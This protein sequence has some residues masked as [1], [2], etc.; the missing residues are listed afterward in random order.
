MIVLVQYL[1]PIWN[2]QQQSEKKQQ[3]QQQHWYMDKYRTEM[4]S[5]DM[6]MQFQI[7]IENDQSIFS[8]YSNKISKGIYFRKM[9]KL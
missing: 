3:Q 2:L 5:I 1:T 7:G 6:C 4:W 9:L 8:Y